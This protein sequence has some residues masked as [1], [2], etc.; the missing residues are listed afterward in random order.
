MA[1]VPPSARTETDT[2]Q[3]RLPAVESFLAVEMRAARRRG[4]APADT[5]RRRL[6]SSRIQ[7]VGRRNRVIAVAQRL[8]GTRPLSNPQKE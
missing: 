8:L 5:D 7:Q 4:D 6:V 2:D 3:A 1:P